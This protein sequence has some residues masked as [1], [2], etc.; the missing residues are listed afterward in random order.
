MTTMSG[1]ISFQMLVQT[2]ERCGIFAE[3]RDLSDDDLNIKSGLCE[4]GG[5]KILIVDERLGEEGRIKTAVSALRAQN[6]DGL[7]MPPAIRELI[8][9]DES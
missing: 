9:N 5:R 6:L 4:I 1:D 2:L 3:I 7:Y 8:E